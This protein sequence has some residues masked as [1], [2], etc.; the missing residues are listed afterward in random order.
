M[1]T[2][3]IIGCGKVGKTL[4]RL[5]LEQNLIKVGDVVNRSL[6]SAEQAVSFLGQG[7]AVAGVY[8]MHPADIYLLATPDD[9]IH[10]AA[11]QLAECGII[12]PKDAVFHCSGAL[13]SSILSTLRQTGAVLASVHPVKSFT[14]P[15]GALST[16][17]GT[18]CAV[19][20]DPQA[21]AMIEKLFTDIGGQTFPVDPDNK[22]IYH[23][24]TVFA[25]NYLTALLEISR[26]CCLKAGID[27][28]TAMHLLEPLVRGTIAN[29][30]KNGPVQALTG[31]IA[32]GDTK[33]VGDQLT[34]LSDWRPQTGELY[35]LFGKVALELAKEQ[36][37]L[38]RHELDAMET[39]LGS[40]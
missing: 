12:R 22:H 15:V 27:E 32:R 31:P 35:R 16:F 33:L 4:G 29:V 28:K 39:L 20:G 14:D 37:M 17:A 9:N 8:D 5:W 36:R 18:F 40:K 2:L 11:R 10:E 7:R 30:F 38:S 1:N 23:A 13:S 6:Q 21:L 19:E 34:A 25:C 26:R 3:N 24:A